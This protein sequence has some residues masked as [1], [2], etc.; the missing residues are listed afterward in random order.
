MKMNNEAI[1]QNEKMDVSIFLFMM[2]VYINL[3]K[4]KV[5][6]IIL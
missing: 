2:T 5:E 1:L 3:F 4:K 6:T